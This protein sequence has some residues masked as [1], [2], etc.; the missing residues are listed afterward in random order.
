LAK[1]RVTLGVIGKCRRS[2]YDPK[3]PRSA[4]KVCL[5]TRNKPRKLLG[6]H[7]N[8]VSAKR[9]EVAIEIRRRNA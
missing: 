8:T 4:Q 5:F 2:D 7:P 3:R 1:Y 9:Q 6:R